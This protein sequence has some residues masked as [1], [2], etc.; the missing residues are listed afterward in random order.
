MHVRID[1]TRVEQS[2]DRT[3]L[4]DPND[5]H[6]PYWVAQYVLPPMEH[7]HGMG[8]TIAEAL[9]DLQSNVIESTIMSMQYIHEHNDKYFTDGGTGVEKVGPV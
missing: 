1:F 7:V 2:N 5:P 6:D 4:G 9:A 3:S 8:R